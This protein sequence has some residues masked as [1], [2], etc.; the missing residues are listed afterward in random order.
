LAEFK[1]DKDLDAKKIQNQLAREEQQQ[2][3]QHH[4]HHHHQQN[5]LKKQHSLGH[6]FALNQMASGSPPPQSR[7]LT[8]NKLQN[9]RPQQQQQFQSNQ[10]SQQE[11]QQGSVASQPFSSGYNQ[12]QS[13]N[14]NNNNNNNNLV[15]KQSNSSTNINYINNN[16]NYSNSIASSNNIYESGEPGLQQVI[17]KTECVSFGNENSNS[18]TPFDQT[19]GST[20]SPMSREETNLVGDLVTLR[21]DMIFSK[22]DKDSNA[23]SGGSKLGEWKNS[24]NNSN[25]NF[26]IEE[27]NSESFDKLLNMLS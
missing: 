19:G 23:G 8:Y 2:Q 4:H 15:I 24:N 10:Q 27:V 11:Q 16:N 1:N 20:F 13:F 17:F 3:H 12:Q 5:H 7:T 14:N 25:S 18:M 22:N 9:N 6:K 21:N 26:G